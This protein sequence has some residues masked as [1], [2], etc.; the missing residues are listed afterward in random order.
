MEIERIDNRGGAN[1]GEE[2]SSSNRM[3]GDVL[4]IDMDW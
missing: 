4:E 2:K 3:N 1:D